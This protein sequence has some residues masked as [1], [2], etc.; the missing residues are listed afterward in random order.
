MLCIKLVHCAATRRLVHVP[1]RRRD[2]NCCDVYR[3]PNKYGVVAVTSSSTQLFSASTSTETCADLV[4]AIPRESKPV[5]LSEL[6]E[7]QFATE[8]LAGENAY[9]Q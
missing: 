5:Q 9:A 4:L 8:I 6:V 1:N 2:A 7:A 3:L